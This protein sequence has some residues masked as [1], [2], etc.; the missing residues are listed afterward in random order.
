MYVFIRAGA[1]IVET[2]DRVKAQIPMLRGYLQPGTRMSPAS[3][4]PRP[5]APR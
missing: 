5:S 3:T 1:N 2:V 4:A